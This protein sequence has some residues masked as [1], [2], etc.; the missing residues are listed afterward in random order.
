MSVYS[1]RFAAGQH[2]GPSATVY[3]VPPANTIVVRCITAYNAG[4]A[5]DAFE[6]SIGTSGLIVPI[7][8]IGGIA[9]ASSSVE[10]EGR[11]VVNPDDMLNVASGGQNWFYTISG[12]LLE[13]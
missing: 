6:V 1:H 2:Q 12:Y 5:Q 10:F 11:V 9:G 7:W 4:G 13:N 3:L 8:H